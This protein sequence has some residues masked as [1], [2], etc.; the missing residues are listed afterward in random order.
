MPLGI[1][2]GL[3]RSRSP[4]APSEPE[5]LATLN[6]IIKVNACIVVLLVW[7]DQDG[8][9][10]PRGGRVGV[11]KEAVKEALLLC[12]PS[13][14]KLA[15]R[16]RNRP[17]MPLPPSSSQTRSTRQH[18]PNRRGNQ[19]VHLLF[20]VAGE[21]LSRGKKQAELSAI[22][23]FLG[24]SPSF[25]RGGPGCFVL[26]PS[27]SSAPLS[28]GLCRPRRN[29]TQDPRGLGSEA[30]PCVLSPRLQPPELW[31]GPL[32]GLTFASCSP[33]CRFLPA[34]SWAGAGASPEGPSCSL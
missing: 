26:V 16:A 17:R 11:L 22:S 33:A 1:C 23:C 7:P 32:G 6:S 2:A 18:N 30:P 28:S 24:L 20:A 27:C 9:I 5:K 19:N 10:E 8:F 15:S 34:T 13:A 12:F 21:L 29:A 4:P 25:L 14:C 3:S 31:P